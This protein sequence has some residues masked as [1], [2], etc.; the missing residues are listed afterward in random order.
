MTPSAIAQRADYARQKATD[1]NYVRRLREERRRWIKADP[2]RWETHKRKSRAHYHAT[3]DIPTFKRAK[4]ARRIKKLYGLTI[5]DRDAM[6]EI[7]GE[8]CALCRSPEPRGGGWH[9]DH[10]H[11]SGKPRGILCGTCNILLGGYEG[12]KSSV[13]FDTVEAYLAGSYGRLRLARG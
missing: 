3:K 5:E 11:V 1:P 9:I 13:S 7:Q 8:A 2:A 10:D 12:L 4:E 6:F